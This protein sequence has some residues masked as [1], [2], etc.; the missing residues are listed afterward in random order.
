M[1]NKNKWLLIIL[2]IFYSIGIAGLLNE[3]TQAFFISLT[4]FNLILTL[5]AYVWANGDYRFHFFLIGLIIFICG[6]T[7]EW[8]GVHTG[9]LFGEY[10]YGYPLGY[11]L[12]DVPI[13]I[14][15]NWFIL[16][17]ASRTVM[18]FVFSNVWL[19]SVTSAISM[20]L[21]D[22]LIEP[23]AVKFGFWQWNNNVIPLQNYFM[24]F[25]SSLMMQLILQKS[26]VRLNNKA[27]TIV[28]LIQVLFFG[29]FF[30]FLK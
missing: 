27:G 24:W 16:S 19:I 15:V 12:Q 9:I 20:C 14:G 21:L 2:L 30:L 25:L 23:V 5:I 7:I 6:W 8:G 10:K 18:Q 22:L 29:I 4:P 3:G 28:F 26:D 1:N 11:Q 17:L 13:I